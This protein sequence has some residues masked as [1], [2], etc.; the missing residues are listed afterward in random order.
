LNNINEQTSNGN[1]NYNALWVT[2]TKRVSHGLQFNLSYTFSKSMDYNSLNAQGIVVQDS[3]N[4]RNDRG[5]SD[6]DARHRIVLNWIYELPFKGNRFK[7]G[8]QVSAI[9]MW[10]TGNPLN[11]ITNDSTLT[12]SGSLRPDL[13]TPVVVLGDPAKWFSNIVCDPGSVGFVAC[14]AGST[15]SIPR[16][17][18]TAA[19]YH[20]GNLGRNAVTGPGFSNSDFSVMKTTRITEAVRFQFRAELFDIFNHPNFGN[21]SLVAT[22]SSFGVITSTRFPGGDFGSSRQAQFSLK[23]LF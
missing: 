7:D 2:L 3:K 9:T 12:G 14:P 19:T 13:L 17:G 16:T 5:L 18:T 8:W 21:P 1:S 4:I 6:F 22:S 10:Q 23:L 11:I 20:F 15:F